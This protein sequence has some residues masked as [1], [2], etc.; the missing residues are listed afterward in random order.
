MTDDGSWL[1]DVDTW[2]AGAPHAR[3]AELREDTAVSW[4]EHPEGLK[5]FWSVN[6]WADAYTVLKD[7]VTYSS[8]FGVVNL[9]DLS[10][11]MLDARRTFLEE[12][13]PR[14]SAI[15]GLIDSDF[16]PRSVRQAEE[17][18]T[19]LVSE[20][21]QGALDIDGQFDGV[22]HLSEP[23]PITTLAGFLGVGKDRLDDL[24]RWGNE[25][26]SAP[27]TN[28]EDSVLATLPFGHPTALEVFGFA[29]EL[30]EQRLNGTPEDVTSRLLLG[31]VD[32]EPLSREEFRATWLMLVI[33]G[34]E[35]TRHAITHGLLAVAQDPQALHDLR[36]D[37][38]LSAGFVEEV[39][40]I[41]T[42]INWHRRQVVCD[43]TLAG[44]KLCAGDKLIINFTAANR[45]PTVFEDPHVF[46]IRRRPNQQM[47]FGR[48]GPHHCLG[49][50]L[51]RLELKVF[52]RELAAAVELVEVAST[53]VRVKSNHLNGF[54]SAPIALRPRT[55]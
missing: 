52:F 19:T 26:L 31:H 18:L 8:R 2:S 20:T 48:G 38:T 6:T 37:P 9:D 1:L 13:P 43:T 16:T 44:V 41:A 7:P 14:H 27:P 55:L 33:A 46:N 45:D 23:V 29:D 17:V 22:A 28:I 30:A 50:H 35:T 15:R 34:N 11:D 40:R 12:D 10:A 25:L 39:L 3:L 42:P 21:I 51:A 49:A 36:H 47:S 4:H 24:V 32:G 54:V 53:P 5:G